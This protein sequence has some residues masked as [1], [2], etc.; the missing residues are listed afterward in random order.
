MTWQN[1]LIGGA[2]APKGRPN[3]WAALLRLVSAIMM[4]IS[5]DWETSKC[6]LPLPKTTR[7]L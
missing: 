5:E 1:A 4:E 3:R 2:F 6:Y 7:Y